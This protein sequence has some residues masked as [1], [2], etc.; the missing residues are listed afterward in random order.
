MKEEFEEVTETSALR[1]QVYLTI[2]HALMRG[3][4]APGQ[5]I[6]IRALASMTGTSLTPVRD[7]LN[8]LVAENILRGEANRSVIVPT[9][10]G[11]EIRELRDIRIVNETFATKIAAA[12]ISGAQVQS[13]REIA[14]RLNVARTKGD[15]ELDLKAIYEFQFT[16]YE[17]SGMPLL[18]K[19]IR[20]LWLKSGPYLHLLFPDYIDQLKGSRGDWRARLC[21]ALESNDVDV[22]C[23]E[24]LDDVNDAMTY[25]AA[26]SDAAVSYRM[27]G[28]GGCG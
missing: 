4:F 27:I 16:L 3:D 23:R 19:I 2:C 13:L 18:L 7:A 14:G 9:L 5:K 26:V 6:T 28:K 24:I 15:K 10:T 8:R 1:E 22:A 12:K 25:A 21:D 11:Q 17:I 20:N